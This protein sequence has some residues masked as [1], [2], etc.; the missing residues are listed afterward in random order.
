MRGVNRKKTILLLLQISSLSIASRY[1][2]SL[3]RFVTFHIFPLPTKEVVCRTN[4]ST[5]FLYADCR[6][7]R[8][9]NEQTS[10]LHGGSKSAHRQVQ[11]LRRDSGEWRSSSFWSVGPSKKEVIGAQIL[12][13]W[14][15]I[16]R[17]PG[18]HWA[19]AGWCLALRT[20][21]PT[22]TPRPQ[23]TRTQPPRPPWNQAGLDWN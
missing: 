20:T 1:K 9:K 2:Q 14:T 3:L 13:W 5:W 12:S 19:R 10:K 7:Q 18:Q 16:T 15:Q 21:S 8:Y 17:S 23:Q 6:F 4:V 22:W 11:W